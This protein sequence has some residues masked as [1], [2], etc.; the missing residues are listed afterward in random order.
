MISQIKYIASSGNE[1]DLT[2]NG[3]LHRSANYYS[4]AWEVRGTALQ[5]GIRVADFSRPPAEYDTELVIY[6]TPAERRRI[7]T[8]LH[9]DFEN[10]LRKKKPGRIVWGD[11]Y[12]DCFI[13]Q[14]QSQPLEKWS[15]IS[16]TIHI[17]APHPFWIHEETV[18]LPV[19]EGTMGEFLDYPYDYPYDYAAPPAGEAIAKSES[20]FESEFKMIIYGQA[21]NPRITINE[22]AY[23]LYATIPAN[24]YV[25]IDSR[26]H[27]ITQHNNDGTTDNLFN[28]RN[29]TNSIFQ[30]IPGG[31]LRI[32]WDSTFGADITIYRERSEP[33]F[34]EVAE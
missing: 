1:Y 34:E 25:V 12:I 10:D 32:T 6:G 23:V 19:S 18:D 7:L 22:Y 15:Y 29:K 30:K 26:T 11:Y 16:D 27:T 3:V 33:E 28:Y 9:D 13:I 14:S 2:T 17:Y 21:V 20:P 24:A 5:Y 31:N 4:W 8:A